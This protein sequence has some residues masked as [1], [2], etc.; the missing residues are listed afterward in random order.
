MPQAEQ[1][2]VPPDSAVNRL[3]LSVG[4]AVSGAASEQRHGL[5]AYRQT[6]R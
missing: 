6:P 1:D 3:V 4:I 5:P 2:A